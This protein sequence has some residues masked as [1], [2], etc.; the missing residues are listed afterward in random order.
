MQSKIKIKAKVFIKAKISSEIYPSQ[1]ENH[2]NI[3][4]YSLNLDILNFIKKI[5]NNIYNYR[6][7]LQ[8]RA[9]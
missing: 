6:W 5:N 3:K 7:L 4:L 8:G 2:L 9:I 1:I